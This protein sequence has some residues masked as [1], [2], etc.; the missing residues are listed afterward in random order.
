VSKIHFKYGAMNSGKSDTLIK[1]AYN[2]TERGLFVI[3]IKP[4]ADTKTED[5]IIARAGN[6][7]KVDILATPELDL[8]LAIK[9]Y[10]KDNGIEHVACVLI[11]EAQFLT[12]EQIDQLFAVA[13][14]DNTSVIAYGLRADFRA[15]LF[16]GSKRLFELADNIEK[17][18]TMCR[19][20][21]QA[22]FNTRKVNGNY[23]FEGEQVAIDGEDSV[24]YDSL[25]GV[26]YLTE[27]ALAASKN[28]TK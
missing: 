16:P 26:C 10:A 28:T 19:C 1:T 24:T 11:D 3:T 4:S 12:R 18:P 8:R 17:L 13:K 2:Y 14:E 9:K 20:G 21:N 22:E 6:Q 7:R 25:C 23:V 5:T 27:K 15:E